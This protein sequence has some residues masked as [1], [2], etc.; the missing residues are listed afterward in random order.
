M[1]VKPASSNIHRR[2][3]CPQFTKQSFHEYAKESILYS[4]WAA[5]YYWQQR[6]KGCS[7]HTA[8]RALA[9]KWQRIIWKCWQ[10]RTIYKEQIYEAALKKSGS[11]IIHLLDQIQLGKSPMK[12]T[13]K[14]S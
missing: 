6:K 14:Q 1:T 10:T 3:L 13:V 4:R 8:V 12:T 7:H 5:A 9:F 11:P 2:Y